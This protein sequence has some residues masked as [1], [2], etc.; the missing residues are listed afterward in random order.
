M[1][2]IDIRCLYSFEIGLWRDSVN[3]DLRESL[4][5]VVGK[6]YDFDS[7]QVFKEVKGSLCSLRN[8]DVTAVTLLRG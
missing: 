8:E 7:K 1:F 5:V 4:T 6:L 3:L 2:R